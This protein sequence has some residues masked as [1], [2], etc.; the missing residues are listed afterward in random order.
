M[1]NKERRAELLRLDASDLKSLAWRMGLT[2][3][4]D[5]TKRNIATAIIHVE[6]RGETWLE[7]KVAK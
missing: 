6:V 7:R 5:A 4:T 3:K 2:F 1:S